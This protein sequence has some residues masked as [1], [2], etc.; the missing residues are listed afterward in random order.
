MSDPKPMPLDECVKA[1]LELAMLPPDKAPKTQRAQRDNTM[2]ILGFNR[3]QETLRSILERHGQ[4][5]QTQALAEVRSDD[6]QRPLEG[7]G[8]I[9]MWVAG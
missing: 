4:S 9:K 1:F 2:L 6:Q 8:G 3:A 7:P 5:K